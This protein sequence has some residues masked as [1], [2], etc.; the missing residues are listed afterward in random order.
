MKKF[1]G[2]GLLRQSCVYVL[3]FL[4]S[5]E[6]YT[7]G[8]RVSSGFHKQSVLR[9]FYSITSPFEYSLTV[10]LNWLVQ[11]RGVLVLCEYT[12]LV[13]TVCILRFKPMQIAVLN[14]YVHNTC[15]TQL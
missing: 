10:L 4:Y 6:L 3:S 12:V 13:Y 15:N 11:V 9:L 8:E 14:F 2:E 1:G 5:S 7:C